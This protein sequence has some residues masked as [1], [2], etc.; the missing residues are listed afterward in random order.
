MWDDLLITPLCDWKENVDVTKVASKDDN[1][2]KFFVL[3]DRFKN[4]RS[5]FYIS[6]R[7]L[8]IFSEVILSE[9]KEMIR[10]YKFTIFLGS[11]GRSNGND[12]E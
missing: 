1:I 7:S 3:F 10:I 8:I 12:R 11:D 4:G 6:I 2:W 9:L 5:R